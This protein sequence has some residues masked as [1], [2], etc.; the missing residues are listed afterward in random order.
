MNCQQIKLQIVSLLDENP[1]ADLRGDIRAHLESCKFCAD[2]Y[3]EQLEL[4]QLLQVGFPQLEPSPAIWQRIERTIRAEEESTRRRP[5][6]E[7]ILDWFRVPALRLVAT[8]ATLLVILSAV[9]FRFPADEVETDLLTKLE[10]YQLEV[11]ENPF[12]DFSRTDGNPF[13]MVRS[14]R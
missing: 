3:G 8:A 1:E 2:F 9:L 4:D 14:Q 5:G 6:F 12:L 10:S 11:K 13:E 7:W